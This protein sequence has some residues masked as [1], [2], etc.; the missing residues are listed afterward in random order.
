MLQ[1]QIAIGDIHGC[2]DLMR[3]LIEKVIQFSPSGDMLVF[4]GDYIDRQGKSKEVVE[5]VKSLKEKHPEQVVLLKGN[6]E[7]LAYR[8]LTGMEQG[9]DMLLWII[10]GGGATISSFG[11]IG[12]AREVLVPF[13]ESLDLFYETDTHIFVHGGIPPG[14]DLRTADPSDLIW[15]RG[16]GYSGEKTLVVGHTP[17]MQVMKI[18][19]KKIICIDT[20]AFMTGVLSAYDVITDTIYRATK[21]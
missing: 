10:N 5:Y 9:E 1:R 8:A 4:L 14:K 16:F 2:Y 18:M 12:Q 19:N 20:G 6:H 13:V 17:Q 7:D 15:D 11:G 3:E 21:G